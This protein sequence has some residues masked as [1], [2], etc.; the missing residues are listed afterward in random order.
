MET[1][2]KICG[3]FCMI[4]VLPTA[5]LYGATVGVEFLAP[6]LLEALK[7]I[8]PYLIWLVA[9]GLLVWLFGFLFV[10]IIDV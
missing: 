7:A 10:Q 3:A 2:G 1:L 8:S 9:W 6:G 5:L 4:L